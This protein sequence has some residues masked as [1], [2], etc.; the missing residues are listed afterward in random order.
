MFWN[1]MKNS[2][3]S[4][5][6][7]V[8]LISCSSVDTNRIAPAYKDTFKAINNAVFGH[9]DTNISPEIIYN[10]PYASSFIKIGKGPQALMILESNSIEGFTWL[11]ADG[12][13]IVIQNGRIVRTK[14]L[15]NNL[16][17]LVVPF[18][19]D[20]YLALQHADNIFYYSYDVPYLSNLKVKSKFS[21][22]EKELVEL[23]DR[24]VSLTL[25]EELIQNDYLG[26]SAKNKYWVD[27]NNFVW[28]SEQTIS[29]KLPKIY[30]EITKKPSL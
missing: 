12:V 5:L 22:K 24:Q 23:F 15:I 14:G 19:M 1:N 18:H 17:S 8:I 6:Y 25:V 28:K 3:L 9:E 10:I 21:V 27:D 7:I 13:Y 4:S 2:I 30:M 11:T 26:W 29:P 20:D 16:T